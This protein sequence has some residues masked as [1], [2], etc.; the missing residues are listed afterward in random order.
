MAIDATSRV[1]LSAWIEG[2]RPK[3][4]VAGISPVCIGSVIAYGLGSFDVL[5]LIIVMLF[6]L[7]IQ[8]GTN[9]SNDYFDYIRGADTSDRKGPRRITQ[10]GIMT[11]QAVY[12]GSIAC[13]AIGMTLSF[14]LYS[15]LGIVAPLIG[16]VSATFGFLY[17][18]TKYAI[19]YNG[20]G[21]LFV[22]L[23]FGIVATT[24]T[25][26]A[27]TG[28]FELQ[29][30]VASLGPGLFS[31]AIIIVNNTRDIDEDRKAKKYTLAALFGRTFSVI[32]YGIVLSAGALV[33]VLFM[34]IY[35]NKWAVVH[36]SFLLVPVAQLIRY[37]IRARDGDSYNRILANTGIMLFMYTFLFAV[38]YLFQ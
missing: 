36:A 8:I 14:M 10:A 31:T 24:G 30:L 28:T 38:G 21:E 16:I 5:T 11:P 17:T 26:F 29:A 23:F 12:Q 7:S 32:E 33:P 35:P 4:L 15:K 25:T 20:L 3:T 13:F 18:A 19:A 34:W 6:S 22:L 2:A 9:L 1:K 37:M 27:Y